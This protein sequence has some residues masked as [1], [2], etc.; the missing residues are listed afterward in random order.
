MI[1]CRKRSNIL[2]PGTSTLL[3]NCGTQLG[4]TRL[5]KW[6]QAGTS[7]MQTARDNTRTRNTKNTQ[8]TDSRTTRAQHAPRRYMHY[9]GTRRH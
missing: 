3:H 5:T 9:K 6:K 7:G 8:R 2:T 4:S 1:T